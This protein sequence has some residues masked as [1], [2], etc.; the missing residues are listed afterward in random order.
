MLALALQCGRSLLRAVQPGSELRRCL[1][2]RAAGYHADAVPQNR[3]RS[4][5]ILM[6]VFTPLPDQLQGNSHRVGGLQSLHGIPPLASAWLSG[7]VM[8][9]TVHL[10]AALQEGR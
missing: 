1:S 3:S 8:Q 2:S 9:L 6:A 7:I 10:F 5:N 4:S